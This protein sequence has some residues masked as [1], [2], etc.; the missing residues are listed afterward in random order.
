MERTYKCILIND[1]STSHSS[2]TKL[3]LGIVSGL[4]LN[5][6]RKSTQVDNLRTFSKFSSSFRM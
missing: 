6:S 5:D 1:Q 2:E 4:S 3:E